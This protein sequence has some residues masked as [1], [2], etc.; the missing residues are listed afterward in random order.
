MPT[1][2][3]NSRREHVDRNADAGTSAGFDDFIMREYMHVNISTM[4]QIV[5]SSVAESVHKDNIANS[6][7]PRHLSFSLKYMNCILCSIPSCH[8]YKYDGKIYILE[9][10]ELLL[11]K[12]YCCVST[13]NFRWILLAL[14]IEMR[15]SS[16]SAEK[17]LVS[18]RCAHLK[19]E[20]ITDARVSTVGS[21]DWPPRVCA[22]VTWQVTLEV[23]ST[24]RRR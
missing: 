4:E 3:S 12:S 2:F 22:K 5:A 24:Y 14:N 15:A 17:M 20:L 21:I 1:L 8:L 16:D 10:V 6:H 18:E 19:Y 23:L 9:K 7:D 13:L 11:R